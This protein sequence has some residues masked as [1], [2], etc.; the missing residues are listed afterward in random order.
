MHNREAY[1][2]GRGEKSTKRSQD[3]IEDLG[4]LSL[5]GTSHCSLRST[6]VQCTPLQAASLTLMIDP[7]EP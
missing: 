1:R 7:N 6:P 3:G 4:F 2:Q 5:Q